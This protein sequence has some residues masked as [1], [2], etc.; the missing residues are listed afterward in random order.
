MFSQE[1]GRSPETVW[2]FRT[3]TLTPP[4]PPPRSPGGGGSGC[5][6]GR[7]L[8]PLAWLLCWRGLGGGGRLLAGSDRRSVCSDCSRTSSRCNPK[9]RTCEAACWAWWGRCLP[10]VLRTEVVGSLGLSKLGEVTLEVRDTGKRFS[11]SCYV[12]GFFLTL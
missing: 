9:I 12:W 8:R 1:A 11:S 4:F 5:C 7:F 3:H 2:R 6:G 10:V